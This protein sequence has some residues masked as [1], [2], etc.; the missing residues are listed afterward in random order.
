MK[1]YVG[2][3]KVKQKREKQTFWFCLKWIH[4]VWFYATAFVCADL[5]SFANILIKL[6]VTHSLAMKSFYAF[7]MGNLQIDKFTDEISF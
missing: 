5:L 1:S 7:T 2:V 6:M 4:N 3:T